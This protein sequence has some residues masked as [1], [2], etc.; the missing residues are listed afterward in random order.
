MYKGA[1][2]FDYDGTLIDRTEKIFYPTE[3]TIKALEYLQ[4]EGYIV[5]L[6]TGRSLSY[7]PETGIDFDCV[8][9]DNGGYV[10]HKN[11]V[12]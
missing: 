5:C 6:A 4:S 8:I 2:F 12:L 11:Q 7:M 3:K 9:T 10:V 1:L